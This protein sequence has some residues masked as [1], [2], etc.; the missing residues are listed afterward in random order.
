[1][2]H[3]IPAIDLMG[4]RCVRLHQGDFDAK[5]TYSDDP[6]AQAKAFSE[7]GAEWLH[8]VDLDGARDARQA[9]ESTVA[10]MVSD[11]TMNV[12]TGGGIRERAQVQAL[13]DAGVARVVI[14]SL[15]VTEPD[16]VKSWLRDFGPD[17]IV[18]ALDVNI[19]NAVPRPALKGWTELSD[20]SLWDVLDDY[21]DALTTVLVTDISRDGVLAG[22]NVDLYREMAERRPDLDIITS[23]GVGTLDDVKAL[24]ALKP[25]GI[26]IGKALYEG[27]F[28]VSEAIAC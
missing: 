19:E 21:G 2:T 4:G 5:T 17:R 22:A 8:V 27:R 1:M 15:C 25:H 13:L 24:K 28:S 3:I 26:I 11:T 10:A 6:L 20:T 9:H 7:E 18:A 16:T 14:G 23:G 12:Q